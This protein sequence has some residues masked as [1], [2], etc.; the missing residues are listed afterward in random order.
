M[1][2]GRGG[3]IKMLFVFS[4]RRPTRFEDY[5]VKRYYAHFF[6]SSCCYFSGTDERRLR[7][8]APSFAAR[9]RAATSSWRH[10]LVRPRVA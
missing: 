3:F 1:R 6:P 2:M 5:M 4:R 7:S 10:T 9:A 8:Q